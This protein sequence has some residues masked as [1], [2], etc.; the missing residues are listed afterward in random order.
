MAENIFCLRLQ[1]IKHFVRRNSTRNS[2]AVRGRSEWPSLDEKDDKGTCISNG[3]RLDSRLLCVRS[4]STVFV[5]HLSE[6]ARS[7]DSTRVEIAIHASRTTS[8][9]SPQQFADV[10]LRSDHILIDSINILF[11]TSDSAIIQTAHSEIA[12]T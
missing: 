1:L 10:S 8:A 6:A 2:S 12:R 11:F 9:I 4:S 7:S 5:S 3:W